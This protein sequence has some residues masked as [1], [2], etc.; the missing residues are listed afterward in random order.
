MVVEMFLRKQ[1][2]GFFV[3]SKF[4]L[5]E[6]AETKVQLLLSSSVLVLIEL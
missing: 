2:E 6:F 4:E 1:D 3:T 5:V